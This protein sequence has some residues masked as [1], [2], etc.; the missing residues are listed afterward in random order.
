MQILTIA[1][2]ILSVVLIVLVLLQQRGTALGS[3]FGGEG[4]SFAT[5][6]GLEKKIFWSTIIFG[7]LFI[8]SSVL[9]L[10]F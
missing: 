3:V 4:A 10:V 8:V 7:F 6:R 1:Q 5:R 2:F 9:N